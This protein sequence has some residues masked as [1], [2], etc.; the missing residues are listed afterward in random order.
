MTYNKEWKSKGSWNKK[1]SKP[2]YKPKRGALKPL[3]SE[4]DKS[5]KQASMNYRMIWDV[6]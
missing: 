2:L 3:M 6:K 5:K 1:E 4:E